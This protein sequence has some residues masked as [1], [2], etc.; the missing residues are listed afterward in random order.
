MVGGGTSLELPWPDPAGLPGLRSGPA[1]P[2]LRRDA[3]HAGGQGRRPDARVGTTVTA[4]VHR[5]AHRP[6]HRRHR[7][8]RRRPERASAPR[9]CWPRTAC[10]PGSRSAWAS[11]SATTGRW[12]S[13]SAGT[14]PARRTHD[15]YLESHLELWDRSDPAQAE[16]AARLRLDLRARRRHGERRARHAQLVEGVRQHRLSGAAAHLAGRHPGGVGAPRGE[17][18]RLDRRRRPADGLQPHPALRATACCW[19]ATPAAR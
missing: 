13:R 11:T 14:T 1:A 10:P 7:E 2:R 15:D 4:P 19:S 6:D 9:W 18:D 3:G 5:R 17:R 8:D 12:A 16:A